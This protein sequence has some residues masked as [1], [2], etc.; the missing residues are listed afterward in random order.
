MREKRL[1]EKRPS[2]DQHALPAAFSARSLLPPRSFGSLTTQTTVVSAEAAW[3][4]APWVWPRPQPAPGCGECPAGEGLDCWGLGLP[5]HPR[6]EKAG[7]QGGTEPRVAAGLG[8][9]TLG[10]GPQQPGRPPS[11]PWAISTEVVQNVGA[12]APAP[13]T[14]GV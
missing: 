8:Q 3:A 2:Y 6:S 1:R 9:H 13:A 7:M 12:A 11:T 10:R 5:L 14:A 4:D